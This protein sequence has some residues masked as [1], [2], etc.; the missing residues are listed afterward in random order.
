MASQGTLEF[1]APT[2]I[3]E[4][5]RRGTRVVR[6]QED[7][8]AAPGTYRLIVDEGGRRTD[9]HGKVQPYFQC[10][11]DRHGRTGQLVGSTII[12]VGIDSN[13]TGAFVR[14]VDVSWMP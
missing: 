14:V 6:V 7:D 5:S 9:E 11:Y 13:E 4:P 2:Y 3:A 12:T 8:E 10:T 1:E